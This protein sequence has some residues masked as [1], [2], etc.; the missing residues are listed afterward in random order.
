MNTF[1]EIKKGAGSSLSSLLILK[2]QRQIC[3]YEQIGPC[4]HEK[5]RQIHI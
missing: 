1:L 3:S 2:M 5:E 4:E